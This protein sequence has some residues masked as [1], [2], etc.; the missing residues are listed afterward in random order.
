MLYSGMEF[1][2]RERGWLYN[3]GTGNMRW[4]APGFTFRAHGSGCGM[5]LSELSI[6][7]GD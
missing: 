7:S 2:I 5:Q 3:V 4:K 1:D 6:Y